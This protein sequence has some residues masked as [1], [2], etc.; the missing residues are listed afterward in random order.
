M[1]QKKKR[2]NQEAI[3]AVCDPKHSKRLIWWDKCLEEL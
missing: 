1:G 3:F 2:R